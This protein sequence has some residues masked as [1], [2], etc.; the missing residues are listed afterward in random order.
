MNVGRGVESN[1]GV[2]VGVVIT[3]DEG[4]H[5]LSGPAHGSKALRECGCEFQ[6]LEPRLAVI[7][8]SE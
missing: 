2:A 8:N 1:P 4:G 7:P 6:R 5:E 3:L